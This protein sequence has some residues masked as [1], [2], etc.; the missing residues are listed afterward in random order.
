MSINKGVRLTDSHHLCYVVVSGTCG[1]QN[2]HFRVVGEGSGG[3]R[4]LGKYVALGDFQQDRLGVVMWF[5]SVIELLYKVMPHWKDSAGRPEVLQHVFLW[6]LV[7]TVRVHN[8][9]IVRL[10]P[11]PTRCSVNV[12]LMKEFALAH[13]IVFS[14]DAARA[15]RVTVDD[16]LDLFDRLH[17]TPRGNDLRA[18][19]ARERPLVGGLDADD[20]DGH[21]VAIEGVNALVRDVCRDWP[22]LGCPDNCNRALHGNDMVRD[23]VKRSA[24][25][26]VSWRMGE[27]LA[28]QVRRYDDERLPPPKKAYL[29]NALQS[30]VRHR[31]TLA[32]SLHHA[33]VSCADGRLHRAA[34]QRHGLPNGSGH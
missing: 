18:M 32:P 34:R 8:E 21:V 17:P 29:L 19:A 16:Y 4:T 6:F 28:Q 20:R 24:R 30:Q 33:I 14:E 11:R 10:R 5:D 15:G 31:P 27:K 3:Q 2:L 1:Q 13:R 9:L 22:V 23:A 25:G 26:F 12:I 7:P